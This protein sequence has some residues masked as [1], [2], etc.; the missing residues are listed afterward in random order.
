[1]TKHT[2]VEPPVAV[3]EV[4]AAR[5]RLQAAETEAAAD[6]EKEQARRRDQQT[7]LAAEAGE[8]RQQ[9]EPVRAALAAW[10]ASASAGRLLAAQS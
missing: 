7:V 5:Q 2:T 10:E 8:L 1:M 4:Q 6:R 3:D 9:L